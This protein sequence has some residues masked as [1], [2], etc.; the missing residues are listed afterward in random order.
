MHKVYKLRDTLCNE[1]EEFG[2]KEKIDA[3]SL[4]MIDKLAHAIKNIDKVLCDYEMRQEQEY[5]NY[6]PNMRGGNSYGGYLGNMSY[7]RGMNMNRANE[8]DMYSNV[9]RYSRN[10]RDY[11]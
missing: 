2:T 4:D 9:D 8:S 5:S 1:L 11:M 7:G 3:Q 10:N 6:T